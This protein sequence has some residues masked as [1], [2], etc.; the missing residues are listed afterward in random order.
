MIVEFTSSILLRRDRG[1]A[2]APRRPHVQLRVRAARNPLHVSE[3]ATKK[4]KKCPC[5]SWPFIYWP[6]VLRMCLRRPRFVRIGCAGYPCNMLMHFPVGWGGVLH[7]RRWHATLDRR[8]LLRTKRP[9][10]PHQSNVGARI[11]RELALQFAVEIFLWCGRRLVNRTTHIIHASTFGD[12]GVVRFFRW[13]HVRTRPTYNNLI[14]IICVNWTN[15]GGGQPY[16]GT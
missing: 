16:F 9:V 2:L 5:I 8:T 3:K 4:C 6:R 7:V 1:C 14:L 15:Y 13:R 12:D 11:E 10:P